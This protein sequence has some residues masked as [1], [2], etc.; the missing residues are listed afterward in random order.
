MLG[1]EW[2]SRMLTV[3]TALEMKLT[4]IARATGGEC[5]NGN[6]PAVY[7][8][9]EA[10]VLVVQGKAL[11]AATSGELVGVAPDEVGIVIPRDLLLSAATELGSRL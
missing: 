8:T 6:C 11:D 1:R 2:S 4:E 9:D 10:T 5:K 3:R 7:A